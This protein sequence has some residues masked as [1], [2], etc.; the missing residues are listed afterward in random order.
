[1]ETKNEKTKM[2]TKKD[3]CVSCGEQGTLT[4]LKHPE[5]C[6]QALFNCD[7][8]ECK[9]H[10]PHKEAEPEKGKEWVCEHCGCKKFEWVADM[11]SIHLDITEAKTPAEVMEIVKKMTIRGG[12][13][14]NLLRI[15]DDCCYDYEVYFDE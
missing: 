3:E 7:N 9:A 5:G 4:I 14:V 2:E 6:T 13:V 10:K 1:M 15:C 12:E 11:A 8:L